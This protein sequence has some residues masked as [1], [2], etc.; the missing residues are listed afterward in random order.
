[1][2]LITLGAPINYTDANL[3]AVD[4][5]DRLNSKTPLGRARFLPRGDEVFTAIFATWNTLDAMMWVHT[6]LSRNR[7]SSQGHVVSE[8]YVGGRHAWQTGYLREVQVRR[9]VRLIHTMRAVH[10]MRS[11]EYCEIGMNGGHSVSAMLLADDRLRAHVFDT[12]SLKYSFP[13]ADLLSAQ[14]GERFNLHAGFSQDTIPPWIESFRRNESKCDLILVDGDHS[15]S[16]AL[17]DI[18]L[19][20]AV[21]TFDTMLLVDD[22]NMKPGSALKALVDKGMVEVLEQFGP[23]P[24]NSKHNPCMRAPLGQVKRAFTFMCPKWGFAVA[25]YRVPLLWSVKST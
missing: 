3:L 18:Q 13:V 21:A 20:R 2:P 11:L 16:G 8:T 1:M 17:H 22:I 7:T 12:M 6:R 14:F 4:A 24:R 25:R 19:L 5:I 23:F 9:M 10:P 15:Y